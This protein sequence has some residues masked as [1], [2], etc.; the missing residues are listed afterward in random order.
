MTNIRR[1]RL[2]ILSVSRGISLKLMLSALA[3]S[4]LLGI[5]SAQAGVIDLSHRV[6]GQDNLFYSNW[7][8]GYNGEVDP[9]VKTATR[10][11]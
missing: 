2:E 1:L 3:V 10:Q 9:Y 8:H 11:N 5:A 6:G 4:A 7:G